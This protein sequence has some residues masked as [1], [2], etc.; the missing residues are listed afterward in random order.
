MQQHRKS[1]SKKRDTPKQ[2]TL[3][4]SEPIE[5]MNFLQLRFPDKSRTT[6]K[7]IL[8]HR[9]VS[10]DHKIITHHDHSLLPGQLV[11]INWGKVPEEIYYPGMRI[12]FEDEYLIVIEKE[13]GLL[14]IATD[15]ENEKTAYS[16]LSFH[17]KKEDPKNKIFVVHRL[18]RETSGVML[19]AKSQDIQFLLQEEWKKTIMER[20]YIA[21]VEGSFVQDHGTITSWLR[22]SKA[23]IVYSGQDPE[24]GQKAVTHYKVLK[25]KEDYALLEVNLE[26]GRKNQIRVHMQDIHHSIVGDKKYGATTSPLRRLGLHAQI[27]S[28]KHPKTGKIVRFETPIPPKFLKLF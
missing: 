8:T 15:K 6:I 27:L 12:L 13:A 9:Q 7:S 26:T 16:M 24:K 3:Q 5:I 21:V 19:F 10:V 28:F 25:Q 22:E 23:L 11:I 17:V 18:D 4:V 1:G 14:S 2:T 20:T